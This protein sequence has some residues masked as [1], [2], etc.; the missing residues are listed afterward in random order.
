MEQAGLFS[1]IGKRTV[2]VVAIENILA[3]VGDEQVIVAVIVVIANAH[4]GHPAG[5]LQSRLFRN[6]RKR[7]VT[8]VLV[9][10]VSA[11]LGW[12]F[13]T[14]AAKQEDIDPAV[15]VVIDER[16]ASTYGL[17]NV[18]FSIHAAVNYWRHQSGLLGDIHEMCIKR[19][20]G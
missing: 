5:A 1:H 4:R 19:E 3:P 15:I 10:A 13:E 2:A 7:A 18:L 6:V 14:R 16:G 12:A 11:T 17:E 9:Q 8:I 20:P